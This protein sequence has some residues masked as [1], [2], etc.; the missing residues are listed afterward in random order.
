MPRNGHL[1][2]KVR[3]TP[4]EL[5]ARGFTGDGEIRAEVATTGAPAAIRLERGNPA[6]RADGADVALVTARI[7]DSAGRVV[8]VADNEIT[9]SIGDSARIIGVGN[10]DPSS[11]EP[12]KAT[13]RSK[14]Y[15]ELPQSSECMILIAMINLMSR[16]LARCRT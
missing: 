3:Y 6:I 5:L 15:E 8:P 11:H 12:D 2:W 16:R 4:G 1:E 14:D 10:G 9:F 7:V 13:R